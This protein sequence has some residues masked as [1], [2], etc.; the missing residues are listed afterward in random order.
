MLEHVRIELL[1]GHHM[2]MNASDVVNNKSLGDLYEMTRVMECMGWDYVFFMNEKLP[3]RTLR[4]GLPANCIGQDLNRTLFYGTLL[5]KNVRGLA[6]HCTAYAFF[7]TIGAIGHA[8]RIQQEIFNTC[9]SKNSAHPGFRSQPVHDIIWRSVVMGQICLTGSV[10]H[11]LPI[12]VQAL[13]NM[14][15]EENLVTVDTLLA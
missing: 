1:H 10:N 9:I 4:L 11:L 14:R 15:L 2:L 6:L 5:E 13:H 8:N 7:A 3:N 12:L